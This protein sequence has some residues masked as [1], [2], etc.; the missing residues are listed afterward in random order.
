LKSQ[1]GLLV[2]T[3]PGARKRKASRKNTNG[4]REVYKMPS[5]RRNLY[6][7]LGWTV[8][9]KKVEGLP[10]GFWNGDYTE[11]HETLFRNH[12]CACPTKGSMPETGFGFQVIYD[13]YCKYRDVLRKQER[14]ELHAFAKTYIGYLYIH[15]YPT[16]DQLIG[17]V[18]WTPLLGCIS[19]SFYRRHIKPRIISL[20][21]LATPFM[22]PHGRAFTTRTT[23]LTAIQPT[24]TCR[25]N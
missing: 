22:K 1:L 13:I 4:R 11:L 19:E 23:S 16:H 21:N 7:R 3:Q 18:L 2:C 12:L 24:A 5:P 25:A 20:G 6:K 17:R 10:A 14:N 8:R 15:L 9:P